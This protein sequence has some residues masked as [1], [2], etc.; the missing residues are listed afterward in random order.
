[1][2]PGGSILIH[3]F[4]LENTKDAPEFAALFSINMLI[5]NP[6]GRSYSEGEL[7]TMLLNAGV[8]DIFRH[9]FHGPNDSSIICGT[10]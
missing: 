7:E 1:M 10:V 9:P 3:E 8:K 6:G 2:Q 4:I 5:N